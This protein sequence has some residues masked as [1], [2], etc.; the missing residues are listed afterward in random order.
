MQAC[1]QNVGD[2]VQ[3]EIHDAPEVAVVRCSGRIV[4]GDGTEDLLRAV[5][6]QESAHIQID[7]TEVSI[8]DAAGLGVLV[9]LENWA[10]RE[11]RTIELVNPSKQVRTEL[12]TTGL[13]SVLQV[14]PARNRGRAA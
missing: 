2:R 11:Y 4:Q 10:R 5:M 14:L 12:E 13:N 6:S 8:I 3:F 9:A 7:L 1:E